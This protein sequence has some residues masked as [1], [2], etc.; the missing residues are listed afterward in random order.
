MNQLRQQSRLFTGMCKIIRFNSNHTRN[1]FGGGFI[2]HLVVLIALL[3]STSVISSSLSGQL[4][5]SLFSAS[6]NIATEEMQSEWMSSGF[7]PEE[8]LRDHHGGGTDAVVGS[9]D[10]SVEQGE[11]PTRRRVAPQPPRVNPSPIPE[12]E[13]MPEVGEVIGGDNPEFLEIE[14]E[15]LIVENEIYYFEEEVVAPPIDMG[16]SAIVDWHRVEQDMNALGI[17][18]TRI[19]EVVEDLSYNDLAPLQE[20]LGDTYGLKMNQVVE[21]FR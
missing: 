18:L 8:L 17:D 13:P 1:E 15:I 3:I 4:Q 16:A 19:E 11:P 7:I 21:H 5:R 20:Y 10:E 9:D 2:E 14:D 6:L 12:T